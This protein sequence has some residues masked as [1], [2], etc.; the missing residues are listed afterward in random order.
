M[1]SVI[2]SLSVIGFF[3]FANFT[4]GRFPAFGGAW[5]KVSGETAIERIIVYP[6][7]RGIQFFTETHTTYQRY[8]L[9]QADSAQTFKGYVD[10]YGYPG[11]LT[12]VPIKV[13]VIREDLIEFY[14][15]DAPF[16]F[17]RDTVADR[18]GPMLPRHCVPGRN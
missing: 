15:R 2:I 17:Q 9:E 5:K 14:V 1:K 13:R 10:I 7:D 16:V 3:V 6:G 18:I 11:S 8:H 4:G 12:K